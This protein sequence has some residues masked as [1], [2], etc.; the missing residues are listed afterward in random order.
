MTML[1]VV[2]GAVAL[3]LLVYLFIAMLSPES[4]Q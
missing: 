1:Y 4:F 3:L 2:G